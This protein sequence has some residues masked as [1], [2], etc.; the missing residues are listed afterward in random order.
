MGSVL[1]VAYAKAVEKYGLASLE[2]CFSSFRVSS[3]RYQQ[4]TVNVKLLLEREDHYIQA[5]KPEYNIA[6]LATNSAVAL[7]SLARKHSEESIRKMTENYSEERRQKV[8]MINKGKTLS[9]DTRNL[10]RKAAS[11]ATTKTNVDGLKVKMCCKCA[12]YYNY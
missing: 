10:M 1:V 6:L 8:G 11:E 7:L 12:T 4:D 2:F 3:V 9:E 5:M